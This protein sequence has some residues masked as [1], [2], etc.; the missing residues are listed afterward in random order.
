ML[1]FGVLPTGRNGPK[2]RL[3]AVPGPV[4]LLSDSVPARLVLPMVVALAHYQALFGPD[5]LRPDRETALEET[6][7]NN[8]GAQRPM[9]DIGNLA[10]VQVPGRS[11]IRDLIVFDLALARGVVDAPRDGAIADRIRPR[12]ADP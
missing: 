2:R 8:A 11:P 4:A 9:P 10:R 5:D 7:G 1:G 12:M 6:L 3:L